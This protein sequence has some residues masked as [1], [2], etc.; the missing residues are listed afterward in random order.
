MGQR[1]VVV[2]GLVPYEEQ[3]AEYK[4]K[5]QN[6]GTQTEHDAPEYVGFLVQRGEIP[7]GGGEPKWETPLT[8]CGSAFFVTQFQKFEG[9]G[10]EVVDAAQILPSLTSPLPPLTGGEWGD[11]AACP[12]EIKVL[13]P[14]D[15]GQGPAA[16]PN[17]AAAQR[18]GQPGL[19]REGFGRRSPQPGLGIGQRRGAAQLPMGPNTNSPPAAGGPQ[20]PF[21][22]LGHG[23][24][25][26]APKTAAAA[27]KPVETPKHYLLR[28][29]DLDV[30]PGKQ[31][32]YRVFPILKN[33]NNGVSDVDNPNQ[34]KLECLSLETT[35]ARQ[36]ASGKFV[37]LQTPAAFW[38][39]ACQAAKLPGNLRLL[40][41]SVE[42]PRTPPN[43]TELSG[44]VR[45]LRWDDKSGF[46]T[47]CIEHDRL[48]GMVLD[49]PNPKWRPA[50]GGASAELKSGC[51]LADLTGGDPLS[52]R[53]HDKVHS[54]GQ[55]LVLDE[56]GNLVIHDEMSET[57]EWTAGTKESE[58]PVRRGNGEGAGRSPLRGGAERSPHIG[59]RG[60]RGAQPGDSTMPDR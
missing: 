13:S 12:P 59:P 47:W 38:S 39:A 5:F 28:Y 7:P 35:G 55:M 60:A 3:L 34:A 22:I 46:N 41:G 37:G 23:V 52:P 4:S 26:N 19:N 15:R 57:K 49:D 17:N 25:N 11:E 44:D 8:F 45:V 10:A 29:F 14:D 53:D 50:E 30:V 6:A 21:D 54:P 1:W 32:T 9:N 24:N 43:P 27:T 42:P 31:Y 51:L 48:R 20:E 36:D 18:G 56:S 2:T 58:G 33:P 40:A 16:G